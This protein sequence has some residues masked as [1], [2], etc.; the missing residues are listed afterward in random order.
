MM[1]T[2][3][4]RWVA[5][6]TA[7]AAVVAGALAALLLT[8]PAWAAAPAMP[9][10]ATLAPVAIVT[11][12]QAALRAAPRDS[13]AQQAVLWQGDALEVRGE[14]FGYLQVY[15]HRRE[16]AGY[17]L[18]SQVRGSTLKPQEAPELLAVLRFVRDTPGAE[19]L[20]IGYAA[21]YLKA[22]PAAAIDAEP[23]DA[24]ASMAERLARR[25]SVRQ[26][27]KTSDSVA[28]HLEVAASYGVQFKSYEHDGAIRL[29]YDGDAF[30]R[31]FAL[32]G[33]AE[34]RAR[35]AL[36]LTRH[37][38]IDPA[39]RPLERAQFDVWRGEVLDRIDS[40]QWLLLDEPLK[41]RVRLRRAGVWSAIAFDRSR[42][43]D[44]AG[45]STAAQR[46]V[47]DLAAINKNEL[48]EN[49][50]A[51]FNDA[52]LRVG[53]VR[54]AAQPLPA[55]TT[56]AM[57]GNRPTIV[58]AA[59]QPGE[60]CALLVDATHDVDA[61]LAKRCSYG[62]I[63]QASASTSPNGRAVALAVQPLEGWRE[64]WV[65]RRQGNEWSVAVLP[66]AASNP[67]LGVVEFAGW[68][69]GGDKLLLAREARV[70]GRFKR[71][72]EVAS[73]ATLNTEKQ[74]GAPTALALF[75]KWQDPAWK[76]S[77]VILR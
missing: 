40:A 49:D 72:F 10:A 25:A 5:A 65:F 13:A 15:D 45:A 66:P 63:W 64:L 68:V 21:A 43:G 33:T 7:I 39:L 12:D 30:R 23:F 59:G 52:G 14:R 37:D 18:A 32:P 8:A 6:A 35:A 58:T 53:A 11:Q 77:T 47:G 34:Q 74:A 46:A 19:A 36:A 24:L 44:T 1:S 69:P 31:V 48:A 51:E 42:H 57:R 16:R 76:R 60:T 67:E 61:P 71:S 75:V 4:T 29:C 50:A 41:N 2:R 73:V 3:A 28:A 38:C 22:A 54:W 26:G 55:A 70:D 27:G 56:A 9:T 20:G 17:V 62:V